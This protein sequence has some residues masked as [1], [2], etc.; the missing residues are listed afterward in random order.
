M[1]A[2][3]AK[4]KFTPINDRVLIRPDPTETQSPGGITIVE[5][6]QE[7]PQIGTVVAVG[8]GKPTLASSVDHEDDVRFG[9]V[10]KVGDRVSFSSYHETFKIEDEEFVLLREDDLYG[11]HG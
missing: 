5:S 6:A 2:T 4:L 11:I 7:K 10:V 3:E 8:P 1:P 9:M